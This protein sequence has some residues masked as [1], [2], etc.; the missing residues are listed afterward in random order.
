MEFFLYS[1]TL[2][3]SLRPVRELDSE[4]EFGVNQAERS[5]ADSRH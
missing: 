1:I 5:L 3:I 4:M 2:S